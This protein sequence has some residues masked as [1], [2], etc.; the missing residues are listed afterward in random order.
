[1]PV[2]AIKL[3]TAR[4]S[5]VEQFPTMTCLVLTLARI[6]GRLECALVGQCGKLAQLSPF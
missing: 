5:S 6:S 1:M 4:C 3:V 2:Q